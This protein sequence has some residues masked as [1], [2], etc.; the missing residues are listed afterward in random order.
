MS[1]FRRGLLLWGLGLIIGAVLLMF[2]S[3][4]G[5]H[6]RIKNAKPYTKTDTATLIGMGITDV[7]DLY[8]TV[9]ALD[10]GAR[11]INPLVGENPEIGTLIALKITGFLFKLGIGHI[12]DGIRKWLWPGSTIVTGAAVINNY[13][14]CQKMGG[15]K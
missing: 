12:W 8:T 5:F 2:L 11:E 4:T 9:K 6:E 1:K 15:C 3:C 14:V 13:Q 7:L 10:V